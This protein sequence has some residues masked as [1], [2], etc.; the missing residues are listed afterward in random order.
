MTSEYAR[1]TAYSV[2]WNDETAAYWASEALF[3]R[4]EI[5]AGVFRADKTE[6]WV[7]LGRR[8]S[9]HVDSWKDVVAYSI[10]EA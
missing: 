2:V 1:V 9:L 3:K 8:R 4:T 7:I 5:C 10:I 6:L